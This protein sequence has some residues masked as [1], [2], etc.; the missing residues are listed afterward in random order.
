MIGLGLFINSYIFGEVYKYNDIREEI[1][2][3]T[4]S[5]INIEDILE[6]EFESPKIKTIKENSS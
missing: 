5:G 3:I 2:H 6:S 1:K 4:E